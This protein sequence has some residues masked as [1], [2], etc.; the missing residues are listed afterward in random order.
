MYNKFRGQMLSMYYILQ[1]IRRPTLIMCCIL[2]HIWRHMLIMCCCLQHLWRPMLIICDTFADPWSSRAVLYNELASL[3]SS[4]AIFSAHFVINIH[5]ELYFITHLATDCTTPVGPETFVWYMVKLI[6]GKLFQT[7]RLKK[8]M[9]IML[10]IF[11]Y[12]HR[13]RY[14]YLEHINDCVW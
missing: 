1:D 8:G 9:E 6:H 3:C 2:Q 5:F 7:Q 11:L 14:I 12:L 13:I 10:C 4:C